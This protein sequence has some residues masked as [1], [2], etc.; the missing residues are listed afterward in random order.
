MQTCNWRAQNINLD[1]TTATGCNGDVLQYY[2]PSISNW[3]SNYS[4][5]DGIQRSIIDILY[6]TNSDAL[7]VRTIQTWQANLPAFLS[8]FALRLA[9]TCDNTVYSCF[10]FKVLPQG[11]TSP[12]PYNINQSC[13]VTS[14]SSLSSTAT[15]RSSSST[16]PMSGSSSS[17]RI[18]SSSSSSTGSTGIPAVSSISSSSPSIVISTFTSSSLTAFHTP[19]T[20]SPSAASTIN[21]H[22]LLEFLIIL[23]ITIAAI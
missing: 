5:C 3:N 23:L 14:P 7:N 20:A 21:Y 2:D 8:Q 16:S 1:N 15:S 19:N 13:I 10:Q 18:N 11:T 17:I 12:Q 4:G 9:V 22:L 6:A